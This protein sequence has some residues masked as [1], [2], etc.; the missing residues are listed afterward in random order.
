MTDA[1]TA[2]LG[3][4]IVALITVLVPLMWQLRRVDRRNT[5]QHADNG[6]TMARIEDNQ[7][8]ILTLLTDHIT[9]GEA[10]GR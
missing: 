10:H 2:A 8:Q 7:T 6:R 4:I 9:D 5:D 3:G 1:Q